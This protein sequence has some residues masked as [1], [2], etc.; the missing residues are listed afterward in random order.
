MVQG[1][2]GES[3]SVKVVLF[4][5]FDSFRFSSPPGRFPLQSAAICLFF[6]KDFYCAAAAENVES[7]LLEDKY[8]KHLLFHSCCLL[9][10]FF[11]QVE[12]F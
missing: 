9:L 6:L 10:H 8:G 5:Q 7:V 12:S 1:W 11:S 3:G 2:R 4:H